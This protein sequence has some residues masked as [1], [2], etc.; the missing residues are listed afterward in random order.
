MPFPRLHNAHTL[1]PSLYTCIL[2]PPASPFLHVCWQVPGSAAVNLRVSE[3]Q[4]DVQAGSGRAGERG[5]EEEPPHEALQ[6]QTER[7]R[8]KEADGEEGEE[9]NEAEGGQE[10]STREKMARLRDRLMRIDGKLRRLQERR[11]GYVA[12]LAHARSRKEKVMGPI[13]QWLRPP[14]LPGQGERQGR[15]ERSG[16]G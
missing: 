1:K 5:E 10:E 11:D 12:R 14:A 9:E 4:A 8:A 16:R 13:E 2:I 6:G 7:E 3:W 15:R